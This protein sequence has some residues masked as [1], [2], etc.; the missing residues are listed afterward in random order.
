MARSVGH[1]SFSEKFVKTALSFDD[2]LLV[3]AASSVLPASV[4]IKTSLTK[5]ISLNLPLL[6]SAMD[7]VT[8]SAF[9]IALAREGGMGVVHKNLPIERQAEEVAR[10]K[11]SESWFIHDPVTLKAT[12]T[13]GTARAI[14]RERG[15]SSF[16]VVDQQGAF[17]GILTKR[18][19]R[20]EE[21]DSRK[22][23]EIMTKNPV[24]AR[25]VLSLDQAKK[26]MYEKKVEKLPIVDAKGKL[27]GL[28]TLKDVEKSR[29]FPNSAKDSEG[30]LRVAAAVSPNEND[31]VSALVKAG[32]DA[33]VVDTAHGH[34]SRVVDYVKSL[35]KDYGKELQIIAGNVVTA[36]A[37]QALVSAGADCVKVGVG[38]GAIC[39]T[40]IVTGVGVPQVTAVFDCSQAAKEM[41][42]TTIS[43]GGVKYS[44]D[45][46]KAIAAGA[47]AVMIGSLFAGTEEA[48]GYTVF[49]N[50]RKYKRYRGMGSIGAMEAGSKARYFQEKVTDSKKF[51]PEGI[52]GIVPYRG[53]VSETA[54]QLVGG[55]RSAM[56]YC[57][58]KDIL[59]MQKAKFVQITAAGMAES[60]PHSVTITEEAPNYS[61]TKE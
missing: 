55:L 53:T 38:P 20:F 14:S 40:R 25:D 26:L 43:D 52:E 8:E 34:S 9:A 23:G 22:A 57:G 61:A 39:T 58:A 33:I 28:I 31:R 44:G 45:I 1:T 29:S 4:D 27:K 3:P 51:V 32:A 24:V 30:R 48:P 35:R 6:S 17:L 49:V 50:G 47:D 56:G 18:D 15:I 21:N 46:A 12:D 13:L 10:V 37:T 2:V 11:K 54:Y 42:A 41:G 7:T 5:K 36:E 19:M 16:P 60:H 59:A